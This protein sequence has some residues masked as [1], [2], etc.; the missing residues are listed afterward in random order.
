[1]HAMNR[2][3]GL[4]SFLLEPLKIMISIHPHSVGI[5]TGIREQKVPGLNPVLVTLG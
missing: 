5:R 2:F 4:R 1:M 3:I